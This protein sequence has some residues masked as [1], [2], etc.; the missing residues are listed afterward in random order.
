MREKFKRAVKEIEKIKNDDR[1]YGT[2]ELMLIIAL[3]GTLTTLTF[4]VFKTK[5][6]SVA[7]KVG[8]KIDGLIDAWG[9]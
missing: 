5:F 6:P 8:D 7:T 2:P 9:T 4:E 1:G 3:L